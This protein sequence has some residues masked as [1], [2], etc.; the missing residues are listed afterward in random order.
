M[1]AILG[2]GLRVGVLKHGKKVR[3][4]DRTLFQTGLSSEDNLDTLGFTLEP[5]A[6]KAPAPPVCPPENPPLLLPDSPEPQ[7]VKR[8]ALFFLL[9]NCVF[10]F[11]PC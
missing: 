1:N 4:D 10:E 7:H 5:T 8:S 11:D 3:D 2:G 9:I 6:S